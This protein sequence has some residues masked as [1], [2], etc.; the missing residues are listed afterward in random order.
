M[1]KVKALQIAGLSKDLQGWLA[2]LVDLTVLHKQP[3][4]E[5]FLKEEG[6]QF[7]LVITNA[8]RGC[9][10]SLM[11][12][13]PN[14]KVIFGWGVGYDKVDLPAAKARNI[15]VTNTP[16]V[17]NECVADMTIAMILTQARQL[18]ESERWLR[19]DQWAATGQTPMG[20]K[21]TGK[22][23]GIVGL[24][25]IGV[26]VAKRADA[27]SMPIRY[28]NRS[29]RQD[30]D[31][32]YESSLL[33]LAKW[34]DYL[35]LLCPGGPETDG[36]IGREVLSALGKSSVLINIARGSVVDQ[37]VLVEMLLAGEVG[38]AALDVFTNE[39]NYP[40]ELLDL[41][42]V[43]MFPHIGSATLETRRAMSRLVA[44]NVAHYLKTGEL[45]TPVEF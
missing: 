7:E 42:S 23:L 20:R 10:E 1:A 37:A 38:G 8:G 33:E 45:L 44:D 19:D 36:L 21:V 35:V 9:S 26:E 13:L 18:I 4:R 14:L 5:Q 17:L 32:P 29:P 31:Y 6:P 41:N 28:H 39:P 43:V 2:E 16:D 3:E 24:G 11:A 12:A 27:F 40:K 22:N 15:A 30:V 25:R 34:S